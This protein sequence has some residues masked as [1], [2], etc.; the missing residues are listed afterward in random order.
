VLHS[1]AV[2]LGDRLTRRDP[3]GLALWHVGLTIERVFPLALGI[4]AVAAALAMRLV[5]RP[6]VALLIAAPLFLA[7]LAGWPV[8]NPRHSLELFARE[9]QIALIGYVIAALG[10]ASLLVLACRSWSG[11]FARRGALLAGL[12]LAATVA[13]TAWAVGRGSPPMRKIREG[14]HEFLAGPPS[15]TVVR[16]DPKAPPYVGSLT[17]TL[18]ASVDGGDLPA[19]IMPPPCEVRFEVPRGDGPV[20]LRASAG[21]DRR[22]RWQLEHAP[23]ETAVAFEIEVDGELRFTAAVPAHGPDSGRAWHHVGGRDGLELEPGAVVTMRTALVPPTATVAGTLGPLAGFGRLEL[24]RLVSRPCERATSDRP[25]IVL[26]VMDTLRVD[27]LSCHGRPGTSTPVLDALAGRGVLYERARATSSWTWPATASI[28][29]GLSPQTHGVVDDSACYLD[30]QIDTIAEALQG[31]GYTTAAFACNPLL[32]PVKNFDQGFEA[33]DYARGFRKSDEVMPAILSWI[34]ETADARFFLYLHLVDPHEPVKPRDVDLARVGVSAEPPAGCPSRP[35]VE[36]RPALLR[37]EGLTSEGISDPDLVLKPE[38]QQWLKRTYSASVSTSDDFLGMVIDQIEDLGLL[39]DTVIAFTSDHGEEFFEH[40][41]LGHDQSLHQELVHVPLILA[42]PG[43]PRGVRVA[44]PVSN[45]HVAWTLAHRAGG[46]LPAVPD[47]IDLALPER[48]VP[49]RLF[50]STE[51]GWWWNANRISIHGIEEWPW[52]L[53]SIPFGLEWGVKKGS[54]P[55]AGQVRLY[56][57]ESDPGEKNDLSK[58]EPYRAETMLETLKEHLRT[59]LSARKGRARGAGE[60]TRDLLRRFGYA[61]DG[62]EDPE[63]AR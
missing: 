26:I 22:F 48:V 7:G 10:L 42:G 32:D 24:D 16:S 31:Q 52:V 33:Y 37:G 63:E 56:N 44:T 38:V 18:D 25:N 29:T 40:G 1:T 41:F 46:N 34:A 35:T 2:V 50:Y 14:L 57:L 11:F 60:G 53:H 30:E 47:P 4:A 3:T 39:E 59:D 9:S 55:G 43:F 20:H 5:S 54:D 49:Q 17:P 62:E 13:G 27:E 36:Y 6:A 45:R 51:H 19:L 23:P 21:V 8:E 58:A 61:G 12:L 15:W 28:L